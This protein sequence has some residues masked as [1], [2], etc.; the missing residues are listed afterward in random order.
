MTEKDGEN[1]RARSG[2]TLVAV[3]VASAQVIKASKEMMSER[4]P[5]KYICDDHLQELSVS[6][7]DGVTDV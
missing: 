3:E 7:D 2:R 1:V 6:V 5:V 4:A